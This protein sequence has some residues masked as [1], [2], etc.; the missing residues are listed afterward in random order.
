[1]TSSFA[2]EA[3]PGDDDLTAA[4]RGVGERDEL[5]GGP[6]NG[7]DT[8]ADALSRLE[9]LFHASL[10]APALGQI[11]LELCP[12]CVDG[13]LRERPARPG[14]EIRVALENGELRPSLLGCHST[15]ASTGA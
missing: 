14:V 7:G 1:M 10:A 3:E 12:H 13:R 4:G 15:T 11:A 6:E 5:R 8:P 9:Q 2:A